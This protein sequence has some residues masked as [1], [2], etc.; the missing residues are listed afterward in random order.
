MPPPE[1]LKEI[2]AALN[3]QDMENDLMEEGIT[4]FTDPQKALLAL[5]AKKRAALQTMAAK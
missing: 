2:D 5:I 4:K 3:V 1:I